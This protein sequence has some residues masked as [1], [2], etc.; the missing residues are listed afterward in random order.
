MADICSVSTFDE[1][2]QSSERD[3][4]IAAIADAPVDRRH[5]EA[6]EGWRHFS[7]AELAEIL[8]EAYAAEV[9]QLRSEAII[10]DS[11]DRDAGQR[12]LTGLLIGVP[13]GL[14][15]WGGIIAVIILLA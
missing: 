9:E 5:R 7:A 14:A 3:L 8:D 15:I 11:A 10:P 12:L 1:T 4:L 6:P 13:L 2:Q